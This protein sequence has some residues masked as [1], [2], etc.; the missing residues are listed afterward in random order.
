KLGPVVPRGFLS[1]LS[2]A[3]APKINPRQ[4]GRLELARWLTS[5]H[6]PL[7]PRVMANR[8]WHYL[9]GAGLVRSVDNFG[10]T[11]DAPSHPEL[12]DHLATRFIREGWSAK[13]LVRAVVLSRAYGLGGDAP[14]ANVEADPADRRVGG[15]A[16]GRL[17]AEELRDAALS[18][19]GALDRPRPAGSPAQDFKVTELRNNGPEA[20]KLAEQARASRHRS[21]YLPLLRGIVPGS[22]EVF[23]PAEQGMV[24][25]GRDATT[26]AP[27]ALY[28]L[29]DPFVWRQSLALADGLLARKGSDDAG[30]IDAA[31]RLTLGRPATA[32]E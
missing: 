13:K 19:A 12:L 23:D 10:V 6:N 8:V 17:S 11:G 4:S 28:L 27:Q 5:K 31:Y 2:V 22:L 30:R 9:F 26:V 1:V 14:K 21:V 24:T 15:R 29:N 32:K 25:G 3:D 20:R 7:T 18:G 16:A